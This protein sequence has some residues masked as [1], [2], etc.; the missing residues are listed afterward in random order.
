MTGY[1]TGEMGGKSG[2]R[3]KYRAATALSVRNIG[4]CRRRRA[5][6]GFN[7][8]FIAD[9]E[10]RKYIGGSLHG[11]QIGIRPHENGYKTG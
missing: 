8:Q 6:G 3:D 4:L 7:V 1:E 5:M 9:T 10:L 2:G 11:R